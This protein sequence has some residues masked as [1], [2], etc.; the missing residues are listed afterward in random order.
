MIGAIRPSVSHHI[1]R[2]KGRCIR[3]VV[4]HDVGE[5]HQ[6]Q[7][8]D[9]VT[10]ADPLDGTV[11]VVRS[12][13]SSRAAGAGTTEPDEALLR[14]QRQIDAVRCVVL[15]GIDQVPTRPWNGRSNQSS[16][17]SRIRST[18]SP[19]TSGTPRGRREPAQRRSLGLLRL[20]AVLGVLPLRVEDAGGS[21][22]EERSRPRARSVAVPAE[23]VRSTRTTS[24]AAAQVARERHED[25]EHA[26]AARND[27]QDPFTRAGVAHPTW[28]R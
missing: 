7:H 27:H 15:V 17:R 21:H 24:E 8:E 19:R 28:K 2:P 5:D 13:A 4:D 26:P 14:Q 6:P 10:T 16:S 9:E 18:V 22:R 23:P 20:E 12:A 3:E 25:R 11:V 1:P